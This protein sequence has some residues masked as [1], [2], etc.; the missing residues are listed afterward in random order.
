ME[1]EIDT[2]CISAHPPWHVIESEVCY[3]IHNEVSKADMVDHQR[4]VAQEAINTR[5][6]KYL[7]IYTDASK[8][9]VNRSTAIAFYIP[10][11]NGLCGGESAIYFNM[12]SRTSSHGY[13]I[14]LD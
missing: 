8:E 5:W 4:I 9:M 1:V 7:R 13:G 3:D 2:N 6:I 14:K 10:Q 12:S 11:I